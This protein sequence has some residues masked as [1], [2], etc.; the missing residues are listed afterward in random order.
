MGDEGQYGED[1]AVAVAEQRADR[2]DDEHGRGQRDE[3]FLTRRPEQRLPL[4]I[5]SSR[6]TSIDPH[7]PASVDYRCF[8]RIRIIF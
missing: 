8:H 6:D 5:T 7:D 3:L 4:Y 1:A 2:M